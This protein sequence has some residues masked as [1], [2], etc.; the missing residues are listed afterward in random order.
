VPLQNRVDPYGRLVATAARGTMM[1]NR[2]VLHNDH[3]EIVRGHRGIRWICCELQFKGRRD[4]VMAPGLYTRLFFLDEATALA[5]GHR[6][7]AEC[8]R[9]EYHA[10]LEAWTRAHKGTWSAP[11]MDLVLHRERLGPRHE[12][13]LDSLPDG[14]IVEWTGQ[15]HLVRGDSLLPWTHGGYTGRT[16]RPKGTMVKVLTPTSIVRTLRAGYLAK[17][18]SGT[19][20]LPKS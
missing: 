6:P 20:A 15:P 9:P 11:S 19:A 5:A 16:E 14:C 3:Q 1:G 18:G 10:F 17:C 12:L 13:A 4:P 7:C 8:R 2:G